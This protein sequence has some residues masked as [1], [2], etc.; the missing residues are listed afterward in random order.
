MIK[1]LKVEQQDLRGDHANQPVKDNQLGLQPCKGKLGK[2]ELSF[3]YTYFLWQLRSKFANDF[4]EI[5]I[6]RKNKAI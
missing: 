2:E 3:R 4:E 5:G 6:C 1:L